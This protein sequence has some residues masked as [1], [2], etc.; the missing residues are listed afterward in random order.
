MKIT[1]VEAIILRLPAIRSE[2]DGTQDDLL[3]RI[4]TDEGLTGWGEVD[5]C[6]YVGKAVIDAGMSHEMSH[7]LRDVLMGRDPLRIEE[8]WQEM[9]RKTR[10]YGRSGA[11]LHAMSGVDL[12]LWDISG[13]ARGE[14]VHR[15]WG[16]ACRERVRAY[17][18]ALMPFGPAEACESARRLR[19]CGFR[20]I[21]LGWGP[22]GRSLERDAELFH[23][24]REGAGPG[25]EIMIDAGQCYT[26]EQAASAAEILADCGVAWLEEPLDPDDLE[27]YAR[28]AAVS[29]VPV[30]A[31]EAESGVPAFRRL[32]EI[33]GV[34]IVQPD[35]SRAGGFTAA[36]EIAAFAATH[37][38]RV[39][40][41]AFK[42]N[43]LLAASLHFCAATPCADRIEFAISDSVLRHGLTLDDLPLADGCVAVPQGPGLGIEVNLELV[44]KYAAAGERK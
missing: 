34:H 40:P 1:G 44:E 9:Y 42:S 3:V 14:P 23:A 20:G 16:A 41:H 43:I 37:G 24:V 12:A 29:A 22:I 5:S 18:S 7:G 25:T 35:L 38:R 8:T 39:I 15:L 30:A 11:V 4:D 2:P 13:K 31:G 21:K 17:A 32:I 28:L 26:W 10:Y 6:P 33:G 27:G 36:R 19:D